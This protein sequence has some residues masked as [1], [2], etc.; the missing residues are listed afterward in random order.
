MEHDHRPGRWLAALSVLPALAVAGWLLAGLPLLLLGR[1]T[2]VLVTVLGV[3]MAVLLCWAGTRG[4]WAGALRAAWWQLGGVVGVAV[5]SGVFNV[6]LHSEQLAVRRDPATYAQYAAWIAAH[7]SLPIPAQAEAFGGPDAGLEFDS[8]GFYAVDG[9]VLPQFMPG[10]P[11]LFAIGDWLG[12]PFVV[13]AVL[14]ALAVLTL[15]GVV[16]RLAGA[17]WAV[18]AATVFAVCMPVLYTS[19]TTFS[20]I[21][22]MILL[23]GGLALA[24][25]ALERARDGRPGRGTAGL[26]GLVFGLAVLVRIDGLRDVLPVLAFAGLLIALRRLGRPVGRLGPPLLAGLVAGACVG[27]AAAYL[28][29]RPYL[30]YLSG[31]VRPLLLICAAVLVLTLAGTAAAP[32]PRPDQPAGLAAEDRRGAD[33]AADGRPVRPPVVPDRDQGSGEPGGLAHVRDDPADP[34]RQRPAGGR[35]PPLLRELPALAHLV[36]RPGDARPGHDRRRPPGA[37]AAARRLVV[38]LAA[39]ARGGGLDDGH[40]AAAP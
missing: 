15:G 32:R 11:M 19:R 33:R 26:A 4:L 25:D 28:L 13:P 30:D 27:L 36:R 16:A 2:P 14:G 40:D 35:H 10:P 9:G 5:A 6:L 38:H 3:P 37:Q 22:S 24:Y 1:F 39:A 23:F 31:S 12:A 18:L 21:P 8:V 20:E 29:A 7:G 17:R 34:A